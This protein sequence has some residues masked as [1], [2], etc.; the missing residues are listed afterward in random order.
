MHHNVVATALANKLT[1]IA[2]SVLYYGRGYELRIS[3]ELAGGPDYQVFSPAE[4]CE[5][6][7][8]CETVSPAHR[9]LVTLMAAKG[10]SANEIGSA[11]ISI[12]ARSRSSTNR[13]DALAQDQ[14]RH[15]E[16]P[17]ATHDRSIH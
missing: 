11:R 3:A 9:D 5:R 14:P 1:R 13:P 15:S 4:V 16:K 8:R 6:N 10:L 12:M 7:R 2:W 17:L